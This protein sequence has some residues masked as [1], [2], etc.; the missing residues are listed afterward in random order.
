[1]QANGTITILDAAHRSSSPYN[2][3]QVTIGDG[4]G[5]IPYVDIGSPDYSDSFITNTYNVSKTGN[6]GV[7]QTASDATSISRYGPRP[8]SFTNLPLTTNSDASAM[9]SAYLAKYKDPLYRIPS[10]SFDTVDP[11]VSEAFFRRELMD[12]ITVKRTPPG[13]GSRIS[14]DLWIQQIQISGANDGHPW[15]MSWGVSPV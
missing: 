4:A 7:L 1:V 11:N 14:Q 8:Q 13:G 9:A 15:Q 5:E 10:I 2:T 3:P 6:G 12:K